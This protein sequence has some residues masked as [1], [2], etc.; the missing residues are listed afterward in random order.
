MKTS[1]IYSLWIIFRSGL[2]TLKTS[3]LAIYM[4]LRKK[5][6]RARVDQ[7]IHDWVNQLLK[8]VDVRCNVINPHH[9]IPQKGRPT[10]IMCNHSSLYDIPISYQAFPTSSIRMLAK[11]EMAR[12]PLLSKAM[13]VAEFPFVNRRNRKEAIQ[14]LAYA[15]ELMES[16]IV[17]WIAPEG[18]RSHNGKLGSFKKGAFVMAIE[19]QA[20][21]IPIGIRGAFNILPARTYQFNL[22]Q[23]AEIHIGQPVDTTTYTLETK[24]ALIEK[25]HNIM[26]T[27]LGD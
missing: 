17:I 11:K 19:A 1:K 13:R 5:N 12:I 26:K 4:Q 16:G 18:T 23:T 3:L 14:D 27:L 2:T 8:L 21:I 7:M 24:E 22:H 10:I 25:V 9:V 6:D 20:T 15:R